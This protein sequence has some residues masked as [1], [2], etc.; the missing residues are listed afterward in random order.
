MCE[1]CGC[2]ALA[3]VAELTAEHDEVVNLIGLARTAIA[4]G[5]VP[6]AAVQARR[7]ADLLAPHTAVEEEALFPA[8]AADFPDHVERLLAD[9][10]AIDAVLAE[11]ADGAG[12]PDAAWS[13]RLDEV[14][15]RLR[16]HILAVRARVGSRLTSGSR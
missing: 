6:A 7:I 14:L 15:T 10:R 11:V 8:L 4:A 1:Y 5:D 12:A 16:E 9:H 3:S 2:Q 13:G